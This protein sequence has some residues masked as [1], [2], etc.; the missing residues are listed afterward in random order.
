MGVKGSA[1]LASV[2]QAV[3]D[4]GRSRPGPRGVPGLPLQHRRSVFSVLELLR[5]RGLLQDA[6][7][8]EVGSWYYD[9]G[10]LRLALGDYVPPAGYRVIFRQGSVQ[11][12]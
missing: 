8:Q 9:R 4:G 1:G 11:G 2:G 10:L 7:A 6:Q 3:A 5:S 12:L